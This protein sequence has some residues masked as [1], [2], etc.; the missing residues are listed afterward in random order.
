[1]VDAIIKQISPTF[2]PAS[3]DD[4]PVLC[5]APHTLAFQIGGKMF[6]VDPRD[7]IGP[8]SAGDADTCIMDTLV[9][10][11][12][13]RV[14]SLYRWSL[15]DTFMKSNLI[16]FH[17]GNLTHPS[18]DPPRIG[19]LST[20]PANAGALLK[21]AVVKA[22]GNGGMFE[23]TFVAAPTASAALVN[24]VTISNTVTPTRSVMVTQIVTSPTVSDTHTFSKDTKINSSTLFAISTSPLELSGYL[25]ILTLWFW[26]VN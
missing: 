23:Q 14:G 7:L 16:A 19:F 17:Y 11:D 15:G 6:P 13:P 25:A 9:S 20:V 10:T 12:P 5:A 22:K 3:P 4:P 24:D 1:M 18:V 8:R 2:D 21:Q 26:W